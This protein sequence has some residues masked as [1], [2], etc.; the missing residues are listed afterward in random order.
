MVMVMVVVVDLTV[1][2]VMVMVVIVIVHLTSL[3]GIPWLCALRVVLCLVTH[4]SMAL[5]HPRRSIMFPW[6]QR[7][8]LHSSD[9]VR[10]FKYREIIIMVSRES[11]NKIHSVQRAWQKSRHCLSQVTAK[12][13]SLRS[14]QSRDL[15]GYW[16]VRGAH[17]YFFFFTKLA[18]LR[19]KSM[20]MICIYS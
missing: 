7:A 17:R 18:A 19:S 12:V 9:S 4:A 6:E 8:K 10:H 14:E 20:N 1:V 5:N 2:V 15:C 13:I 16:S 11:L 3:L